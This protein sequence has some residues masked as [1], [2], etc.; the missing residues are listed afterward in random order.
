MRHSRRRSRWTRDWRRW[1]RCRFWVHRIVY[2]AWGQNREDYTRGDC[3]GMRQDVGCIIWLMMCARAWTRVHGWARVRDGWKSGHR[4]TH[5]R[6]Q[7][8]GHLLLRGVRFQPFL[9]R[10]SRRG[11]LCRSLAVRLTRLLP[12]VLHIG[13]K[14]LTET[15]SSETVK[16]LIKNCP[17]RTPSSAVS[18]HFTENNCRAKY[19]TDRVH[20]GLF[21]TLEVGVNNGDVVIN[22]L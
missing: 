21:V 1:W 2:R 9:S 16:V 5:L 11:I 7:C 12:L 10:F 6:M 14:F 8:M 3:M 15:T 17:E 20:P 22:F 4:D 18:L 19:V 13:T